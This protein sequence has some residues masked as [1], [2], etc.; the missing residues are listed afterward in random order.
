MHMD[1]QFDIIMMHISIK[2][3]ECQHYLDASRYY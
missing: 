1:M 3:V 2:H